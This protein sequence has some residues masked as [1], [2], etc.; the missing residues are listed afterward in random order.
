MPLERVSSD[1]VVSP[2]LAVRRSTPRMGGVGIALFSSAIFGLSGSFAKALLDSGWSPAAAVTLRLAGASLVLLVPTLIVMRGKWGL[3]AKNWKSILLFGFFGVAIC[4]FFY[5]QAVERLDVGVALLLEF[6]A[7]VLIV[8]FLWIRHRKRPEALTIGG[9]MLSLIGLAAVLDLTGS[10]RVDPIGVLWGLGAAV[11]LVVYFFVSARVEGALPPL[12]LA[13]GGLS[14]GAVTMA[15]LAVVGL[16][17]M[18]MAFTPV[19]LASWET[20]WWVA[21]GGLVL[22]STVI[23]YV[24]GIMAARALGSKLASF[25]SLT[26][27]LFAVVWAWLLLG[28]LPAGIQLL[29]GA[30]IVGGVLLVRAD[31]MRS[32]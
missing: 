22:F 7:P 27:V 5:F 9:T 24:T 17:E 25:I 11:G 18:R 19:K 3:A 2:T 10:T 12:V 13:T 21:L 23:S 31:E 28:Q 29:G 16:L 8:I 20:Q 26:E 30:L 32:P 4:Q 15:L 1:P 14:V 6:L